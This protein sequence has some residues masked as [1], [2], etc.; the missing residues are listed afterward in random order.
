MYDDTSIE[1]S[2]PPQLPI[3]ELR[4]ISPG[5]TRLR[6]LVVIPEAMPGAPFMPQPYRGMSGIIRAKLEPLR[7][8][9]LEIS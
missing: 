9:Y 6:Q 2:S 5:L 8:T 4:H 1:P 3:K 7:R